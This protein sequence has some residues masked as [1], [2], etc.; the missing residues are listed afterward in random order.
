MKNPK[1]VVWRRRIAVGST[2][3]GVLF[4]AFA[5]FTY[6]RYFS[7]PTN[8]H[9]QERLQHAH[10]LKNRALL[11]SVSVFGCSTLTFQQSV[12]FPQVVVQSIA[13]SV[14]AVDPLVL[15]ETVIPK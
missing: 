4:F 1:V 12:K 11:C 15:T 3:M 7:D 9:V 14:A 13:I 2:V 5:Y 6:L 10:M 8:M